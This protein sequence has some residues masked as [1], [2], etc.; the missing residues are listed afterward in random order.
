MARK[1]S[2]DSRGRFSSTGATARGK[3]L[4]GKGPGGRRG[5]NLDRGDVGRRSS[6]PKGTVGGTKSAKIRNLADRRGISMKKAEASYSAQKSA[7]TRKKKAAA[8]AVQATR[9][10]SFSS[11][12]APN[13]AK[14]AYKAATSKAREAK[15]L[16]GGRTSTK[17]LG[18]RTDAG[19]QNIRAS[20]K[21]AQSAAS[22]VRA[23]EKSRGATKKRKR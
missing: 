16:A 5:G 7:V 17:G 10:K 12:A 19:A 1:Y 20:V 2:R 9:A 18:K 11:K 13:K 22:K 8:K 23:M 21:A 6:V 3:R 15:M 14:A 4:T